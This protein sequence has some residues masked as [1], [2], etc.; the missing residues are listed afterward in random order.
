M[1][2]SEYPK[3]ITLG[4]TFKILTSIK[5]ETLHCLHPV[6]M[7]IFTIWKKKFSDSKFLAPPT[8]YKLVQIPSMFY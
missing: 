8:I 4:M 7:R 1:N 5:Q 6:D 2:I 3:Y